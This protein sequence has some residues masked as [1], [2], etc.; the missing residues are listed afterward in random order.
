MTVCRGI[1]GATTSEGNTRDAI[2][3]ATKELFNKMVAANQIK[4]EQ[5]ASVFFT[6]TQDLDAAFPATAVREIGWE[7]TAL[8]C[9]NEIAVP[10]SLPMCIRVLILVNTDK[11]PQELVNL[12]LNGAAN[13]RSV[14]SQV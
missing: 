4:E 9:G 13:L 11:A 12:Y 14:V 8:M 7:R 2:F 6:T 5:V 10:G 1:R 3:A